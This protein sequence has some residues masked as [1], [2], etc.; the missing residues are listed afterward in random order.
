MRVIG[1]MLWYPFR[2]DI[3]DGLLQRLVGWQSEPC[4]PRGFTGNIGDLVCK[5]WKSL[6]EHI[7]EILDARSVSG[8]WGHDRTL[9]DLK[10]TLTNCV[11]H[12]DFEALVHFPR[13]PTTKGQQISRRQH[14]NDKIR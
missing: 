11:K 5:A 2:Y 13:I 6:S 9:N 3:T 12:E 4:L 10:N 14:M 1:W 8:S 7:V